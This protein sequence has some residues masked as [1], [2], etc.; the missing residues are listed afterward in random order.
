[1][2]HEKNSVIKTL[3]K[4]KP[5]KNDCHLQVT[6]Y[7]LRIRNGDISECH[8][9]S[10]TARTCTYTKR[11]MFKSNKYEDHRKITNIVVPF[12]F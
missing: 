11:N 10:R 5:A 12:H 3:L 8:I 7:R 1:M 6:I 2:S 9:R 4:S